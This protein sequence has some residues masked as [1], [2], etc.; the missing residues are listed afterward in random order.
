MEN[1][2]Y[3]VWRH[4]QFY[5][6]LCKPSDFAEE[7]IFKGLRGGGMRRLGGESEGGLC[8]AGRVRRIH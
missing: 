2:L 6:V 1:I 8:W 4:L 5:L 3:L 7:L